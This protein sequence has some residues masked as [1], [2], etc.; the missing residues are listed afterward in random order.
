MKRALV[1]GLLL[2][3]GASWAGYKFLAYA[4]TPFVP[5]DK[6]GDLQQVL[7]RE[8]RNTPTQTP[9][10][11]TKYRGRYMTFNYPA[12]AWVHEIKQ[13]VPGMLERVNM[14]VDIPRLS[15]VA[16]AIET[17]EKKLE[18]VP[19]V[20]MRRQQPEIYSERQVIVGVEKNPVFSKLDGTEKTV[21][22]I[23]HERLYTLSVTG[24]EADAVEQLWGEILPTFHFL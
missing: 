5:R 23:Y 14:E 17:K 3:L 11:E 16:A 12:R 4:R 8:I 7:G 19:G 18:D 15:I 20:K 10:G 13:D 9:R 1:F 21:F 6:Q 2:G 24:I 22:V